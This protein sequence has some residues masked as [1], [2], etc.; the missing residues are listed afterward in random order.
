MST[1]NEAK[2]KLSPA[3]FKLK[4]VEIIQLVGADNIN[5]SQLERKY[6]FNWKTIKKYIKQ[7]LSSLPEKE[8]TADRVKAYHAFIGMN[9][10]LGRM[11][12]RNRD[13]AEVM[14]KLID[15]ERK[16]Y[17]TMCKVWESFGLKEKV[18]EEVNVALK[19]EVM[20]I[21]YPRTEQTKQE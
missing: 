11:K 9:K 1:E 12:L 16:V 17:D 14:T 10:E 15:T 3:E 20:R 7:I 13:N 2:K 5:I 21:V 8:L 18:A 19:E 4:I 6:G